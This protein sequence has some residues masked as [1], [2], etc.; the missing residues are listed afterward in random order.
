MRLYRQQLQ[1]LLLSRLFLKLLALNFLG[2]ILCLPYHARMNQGGGNVQPPP[3]GLGQHAPRVPWTRSASITDKTKPLPNIYVTENGIHRHFTVTEWASWKQRAAI[4]FQDIGFPGFFAFAEDLFE[5]LPDH[6]LRQLFEA[7]PPLRHQDILTDVRQQRHVL[8]VL[9]THVMIMPE[10]PSMA[11]IHAA[12]SD[13]IRYQFKAF[14]G[15]L[16]KIFAALVQASIPNKDTGISQY[17]EI[18]NASHGPLIL[19]PG[20]HHP[21]AAAM[22]IALLNSKF[23]NDPT[24]ST[25]DMEDALQLWISTV[26]KGDTAALTLGNINDFLSTVNQE[27]FAIA[28]R[29]PRGEYSL[30]RNIQESVRKGLQFAC[31]RTE[32]GSASEELQLAATNLRADVTR[33]T[34]GLTFSTFHSRLISLCTTHIPATTS[35]PKTPLPTIA[36]VVAAARSTTRPS[37]AMA[38]TSSTC[39]PC[40]SDI[41]HDAIKAFGFT[42]VQG[43]IQQSSSRATPPHWMCENCCRLGHKAPDC[44]FPTDPD[45][46]QKLKA[47]REDRAAL[48]RKQRIRKAAQSS[49]NKSN[50]DH[51]AANQRSSGNIPSSGGRGGGNQRG[52][53]G[54]QNTS[55]GSLQISLPS[56]QAASARLQGRNVRARLGNGNNQLY[57]PSSD[58]IDEALAAFHQPASRGLNSDRFQEIEEDDYDQNREGY[59]AFPTC[60][61]PEPQKISMPLLLLLVITGFITLQVVTP[62]DDLSISL[63]TV[64]FPLIF[65]IYSLAPLAHDASALPQPLRGP[66]RPRPALATWFRQACTSTLLVLAV[67]LHIFTGADATPANNSHAALMTAAARRHNVLIDTG[68]SRTLFCSADRLINVRPLAPVQIGGAVPGSIVA[69]QIGDFPLVLIDEYGGRH[70]TIIRDCM[71]AASA[72]ANLLSHNDLRRARIGILVPDNEEDPAMLFWGEGDCKFHTAL[73]FKHGLI[74]LPPPDGQL[75]EIRNGTATAAYFASVQAFNSTHHQLRPLTEAEKWHHRLCHA[76]P[77]KIAKLSHACIGIKRPLAEFQV[78]C[79]DCMDANIRRSDLPPPSQRTDTGAWNVD[80]IDMGP[81]HL[82][83]GKNRY[84]TNIT[85]ADSRYVMLFLHKTKDEFASI[86][87]QA[88]ARTPRKP[89]ILR[90]DGAGEYI[91]PAVNK[92]LNDHGIR[93]ETSNPEEQFGNGKAETMVASIGRGMRVALLSSGLGTAFWGFAALNWIDVYNHLPHASLG[94]KTPWEV[95]MG[96]TPDVSWFRPF[97]CRVTVFRGRDNVDHH[98][99]APRGEPCVYVGLGFHRGQ[100]GW[101]CW[102]PQ[103]QRVYCTRHCVFDETFM[104]MRTSDQRI[105]GYYDTTPRTKMIN[106]QF[107][108]VEEA[109]KASDDLWDLPAD[110]DTEPVDPDSPELAEPLPPHFYNQEG[111]NLLDTTFDTPPAPTSKRPASDNGLPPPKR[112]CQDPWNFTSHNAT[113]TVS[114]GNATT[115]VSGGNATTTVSGGNATTTVSGGKAATAP[116]QGR[117]S[118]SPL[119]SSGGANS[120]VDPSMLSAGVPGP[121]QSNRTAQQLLDDNFDWTTLGTRLISDVNN[122]ELTEWLIGHSITLTFRREFWPQARSP[123]PWQGFIYDTTNDTRRKPWARIWLFTTQERH[124]VRI[125]SDTGQDLTIRDAVKET[126]PHAVTLNDMLEAFLG[127]DLIKETHL[128]DG[129]DND[130][131]PPS[132]SN[133]RNKAKT[134][135]ANKGNTSTEPQTDATV[136]LPDTRSRKGTLAKH[137]AVAFACLREALGFAPET[138]KPVHAKRTEM[139]LRINNAVAG[140]TYAAL[141]ATKYVCLLA[142]SFGYNAAFMS[143]EPRSQRDARNRPDSDSW[144]TAEQTELSTLWK[145]GTFKLVNR[146]ANYDP[147][148]LHFVYKLKVKDGDFDNVTYK[149]RLVMNGNLQYPGEYGDTYA[150]TARLWSLRALTAVAAQEGLTLKKFD[151]TGAFLVADMDRELYVEIPG[152]AV[153]EGKALLLKK[154]LY[155]GRSSGALYNKEI[156]TWL[157]NYGFKS[158]SIDQ[159]LFRMERNGPKGKEVIL[160]SLYVDDGAC[161]TNSEVFYKEFIAAL[162]AK[163]QLSDQGKLEWHLGMKFTQDLRTGTIKI[164]QKAYIDAVLKRFDMSDANERDTPLEPKVRLSKADCPAVPDKKVVKAYQQLVGS[165]MYIACATRPDIAYA[166]NT[167]AQ[168]MTNPGPRHI[169]AA[170]HVLRYLKGTKDVGI[171]YSKQTNESMANK[172]FGYVDADHAADIDDRKSVGGYVLLLNGGAV[173][174]SSRKIKVVAISSFESEWYS[175]SIAGCEVQSMRRLLEEMGFKQTEPT[176]LFEDNAGCIYSSEADRP[177]NP[178]SKHIDT[179]VFKLKEFVQE[180]TLKLVKVSSQRQVADNLTKPLHKVGVEMAR[181]IMSGE[182]AAREAR[183]HSARYRT[184]LSFMY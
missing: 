162:Q 90:T 6:T 13:E 89:K 125:A 166:V 25:K 137:A 178:C 31:L 60:L 153:P 113:T 155:G 73:P 74:P 61:S 33:L 130:E 118:V 37:L 181:A 132:T 86:L 170:K 171:T 45:R 1:R 26:S 43:A 85:C 108:S 47:H 64:A 140:A 123:G 174:W 56:N 142:S 55:A 87:Q 8:E 16:Y 81:K 68:C 14:S 126:Y 160:L 2:F 11:E 154:A 135:K 103:T 65:F 53:R 124:V 175:A 158:T 167:C 136:R 36:A 168:F 98:K 3:Q 83:L 35:A 149:A 99:L 66:Q 112:S 29:D 179:R 102:S 163:Y 183:A 144:Q 97:G 156:T 164:D 75:T 172:L 104:P 169:E 32:K 165:L 146:P 131:E 17:A 159:T 139:K 138:A 48:H 20:I 10:L 24:G 96:T 180:G 63:V 72:Q 119:L 122:Y 184:L 110:F 80:M 27:F 84:V 161:A 157:R 147:L 21:L 7:D 41:I 141:V 5:L 15:L 145:M 121:T 143:P 50:G 93:K 133:G 150:P 88:L 28:I 34:T 107:G 95:E 177:M 40:C 19:D 71:V 69:E 176:T 127:S 51:S 111:D 109:V 18:F 116:N 82:S 44:K 58:Q 22:A 38:A 105:L 91:T 173:S 134:P 77:S 120:G 42:A 57:G 59:L 9:S 94:F 12:S 49:I 128:D 39:Q 117:H 52:P 78:P 4:W 114:G 76:H 101:L 106:Q 62:S 115:T 79:H 129:S 23:Q 92:I 100:K 151:L 67:L 152:Y 70:L 30:N 46:E 148:P 182:E 54:V